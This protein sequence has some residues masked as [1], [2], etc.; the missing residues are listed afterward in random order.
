MVEPVIALFCPC[1]VRQKLLADAVRDYCGL[2]VHICPTLDEMTAILTEKTEIVA[3]LCVI[4]AGFVEKNQKNLENLTKNHDVFGILEEKTQNLTDISINFVNIWH[5]PV[6]LGYVCTQMSLFL[7][8][9]QRIQNEKPV[10]MGERLLKPLESVLIV[11]GEAIALTDKERDILLFL[12][13]NR[14]TGA[15]KKEELLDHVWRYAGNV[16]THTLETHIYRLRQKIEE[17]SS[18]PRFLITTDDGYI[19]DI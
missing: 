15:V 16:E 10:K 5:F 13:Q 12:Y 19:L 1:D 11:K 14:A 8:Q 9:K 18:C 3:G 7:V 6:R 17:D 2:N 4:S